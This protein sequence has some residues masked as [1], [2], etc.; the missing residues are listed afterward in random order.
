MEVMSTEEMKSVTAELTV[1][2]F[3]ERSACKRQPY[4]GRHL[5][6]MITHHSWILCLVH[7]PLVFA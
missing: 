5:R 4:T 6:G 2:T 3:R 1:L 7:V